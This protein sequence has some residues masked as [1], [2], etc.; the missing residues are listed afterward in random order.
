MTSIRQ[1]PPDPEAADS[2]IG[3]NIQPQVAPGSTADN[4]ICEMV[5]VVR[6]QFRL[7]ENF[8]PFEFRMIQDVYSVTWSQASF[9]PARIRKVAFVVVCVDFDFFQYAGIT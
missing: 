6:P 4:F 7:S 5:S 9:N 3:N 1:A 8:A 2:T